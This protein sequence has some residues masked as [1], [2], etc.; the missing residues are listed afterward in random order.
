MQ[1]WNSFVKFKRLFMKK[2]KRR[3]LEQA[4]SMLLNITES[5]WKAR[6]KSRS[7]RI[8]VANFSFSRE[9]NLNLSKEF[10]ERVRS[11]KE[12]QKILFKCMG[13]CQ[14][15]ML[16]CKRFECDYK[17]N[18]ILIKPSNKM[19]NSWKLVFVYSTNRF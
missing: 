12:R 17:H 18:P 14:W 13:P 19:V 2:R 9:K 3:K 5:C 4:H 7:L 16:E 11:I 8:S 15:K 10:D 6:W 1:S